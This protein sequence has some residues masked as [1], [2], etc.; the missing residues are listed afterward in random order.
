MNFT[1]Y[2]TQRPLKPG[3]VL[4]L[5]LSQQLLLRRQALLET[6]PPPTAWSL[7][8]KYL[9]LSITASSFHLEPPPYSE[10]T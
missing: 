10:G 4:P 7:S 9:Y 1:P 8:R 3:E 5:G 6:V 2:R